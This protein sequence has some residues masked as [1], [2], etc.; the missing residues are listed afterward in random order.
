[1]GDRAAL[2]IR[3]SK[4]EAQLIRRNASAE[5][6]TE[7]GYILNILAK[8][9]RFEDRLFASLSSFQQLNQT[10]VRKPVRIPGPKT[11]MLVRC[12]REEAR[13]IRRAA[14]RRDITINAFVTDALRRA[15]N[16]LGHRPTP[17]G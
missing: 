11:T 9:L 13:L 16:I 6:R 8:A 15:W 3:C 2:L 5:H 14:K 4:E 7:S 17:P 1:M 12:S 10:L